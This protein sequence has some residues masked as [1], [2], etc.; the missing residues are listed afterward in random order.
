MNSSDSNPTLSNWFPNRAAVLGAILKR[1]ST[2]FTATPEPCFVGR[3]HIGSELLRGKFSFSGHCVESSSDADIWELKSPGRG[4]ANQIHGFG[5][6]DDLA[7]AGNVKAR[8]RA[9]K[10]LLNWINRY[11]TGKGPGWTPELAARRMFRW[12]NHSRFIL[13]GLD[14]RQ[15]EAFF[16]S[17]SVQAGF[18]ASRWQASSPGLPRIETVVGMIYA[19]IYLDGMA[20]HL[21]PAS[22]ALDVECAKQIDE[23][24]GIASRNPEELLYLFALLVWT[25]Q[26][27]SEAGRSPGEGHWSAIRRMALCMRTLRHSDGGLPRFH[28]GGGG[29]EGHLDSALSNSGVKGW[30][31]D[32]KS[33]G[34]TRIAAGRCTVIIDSASP[35]VGKD[36]FKAHASTLAFELT[37]GL[38]PLVVNCGHGMNMDLNMQK[39]GRATPSH[40]TLV[41]AGQ[42]SSRISKGGNRRAPLS[43]VPGNVA[44]TT[45]QSAGGMRFYGR[46]DGYRDLTGLEHERKLELSHDGIV[47]KGEDLLVADEGGNMG[48]FDRTR[49]KFGNEGIYFE[50]RFHLHPNVG[51]EFDEEGSIA[52]MILENGESWMLSHDGNAALQLERSVYFPDESLE[53]RATSQIVLSGSAIKYRTRIKWRFS[54]FRKVLPLDS[55]I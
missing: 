30:L 48:L 55:R 32:G 38:C 34:F 45:S 28:G 19:G 16:R 3:T 18:L 24:G 11:G 23:R 49:K 4:F 52:R 6:L 53:P 43:K 29:T 14:K 50:I 2:G 47:L 9:Q 37:S 21:A 51:V 1:G 46:H 26:S 33:M 22:A 25:A 54:R 8:K 41:L 27:I 10:W 44:S 36:S 7:A 20:S 40:S 15:S 35:P 13:K 42:S 39:A 12:I 17:M 31:T 5:W